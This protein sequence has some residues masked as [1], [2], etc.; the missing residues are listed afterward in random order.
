MP[1]A[2]PDQIA[3]EHDEAGS[4]YVLASSGETV[5]LISYRRQGEVL[6]LLH[7]EVLPQG[8]GKGIGSVLVREVL[9]DVR[10]KGE[11]I[12]PSCPFVARFIEEHQDYADLV[13]SPR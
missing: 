9:D 4:R 11:Q 5:G 1:D 13:E 3:L 2:E 6:E 8:R 10:A 7:T 12:V